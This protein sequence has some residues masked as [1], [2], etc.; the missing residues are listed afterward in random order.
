MRQSGVTSDNGPVMRRVMVPNVSTNG[1]AVHG[2]SP[3][4]RP[5]RPRPG[6]GL[7]RHL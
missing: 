6:G 2:R 5:R 3:R 4:V 1:Q 7:P